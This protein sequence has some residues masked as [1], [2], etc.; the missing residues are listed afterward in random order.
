MELVPLVTAFTVSLRFVIGVAAG[1]VA[2][3]VMDLVMARLPEGETPPFIAS[4]VLTDSAPQNAPGRLA[5]VVHYVAGWLTGPLF[6]WVLFTSEGLLS[7]PSILAAVLAAV[8]LYTLMIGFFVFVVLP[9]SRLPSARIPDIR[10]D[11]AISA[12]AYLL[13]LVPLVALGFRFV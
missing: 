5:S 2:T 9:R 13:V 10:R 1:V 4:G 12:A 11:W 7:G 3:V 6:V 8:V